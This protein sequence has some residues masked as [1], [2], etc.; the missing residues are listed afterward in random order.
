MSAELRQRHNTAAAA[1]T[2]AAADAA[3]PPA[4]QRRRLRD[5]CRVVLAAAVWLTMGGQYGSNKIWL[6]ICLACSSAWVLAGIVCLPV[7]AWRM[8]EMAGK[9]LAST[10]FMIYLIHSATSD[11]WRCYYERERDSGQIF[12]GGVLVPL[13]QWARDTLAAAGWLGALQWN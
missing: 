1:G 11:F 4:V 8:G 2:E 13:K 12:L 7:V 6:G 9:D 3:R 10:L 5:W